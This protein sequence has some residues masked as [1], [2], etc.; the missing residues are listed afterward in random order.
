MLTLDENVGALLIC[1]YFTDFG[2][3]FEVKIIGYYGAHPRVGKGY[4]WGGGP[5]IGKVLP[6][7]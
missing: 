7:Q 4:V 5:K 1:R 3:Q 6:I 2:L